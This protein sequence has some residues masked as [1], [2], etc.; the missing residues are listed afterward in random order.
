MKKVMSRNNLVIEVE[1]W[2]DG[3]NLA[4]CVTYEGMG[5]EAVRRS[6][7]GFRC[8]TSSFN[9]AELRNLSSLKALLLV[10]CKTRV[11][12]LFRPNFRTLQLVYLQQAGEFYALSALH[13]LLIVYLVVTSGCW[14]SS[15]DCRS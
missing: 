2:L 6:I 11:A 12:N 8:Y 13:D 5:D 3:S 10:S 4:G 9:L 15:P 14:I 7:E 1:K